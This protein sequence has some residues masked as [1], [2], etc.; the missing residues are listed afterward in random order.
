MEAQ[1][2][3]DGERVAAFD[4]VELVQRHGEHEAG[5]RGTVVIINGKSALVDF[6]WGPES[7]ARGSGR[8]IKIPSGRL[9]VIGRPA[10]PERTEKAP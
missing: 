10:L 9:R 7:N 5:A 1:C 4:M 2:S 8:T 6:A 3:A